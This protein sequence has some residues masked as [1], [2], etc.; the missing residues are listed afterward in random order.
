MK[1]EKMITSLNVFLGCIRYHFD[2]PND[3]HR[4]RRVSLGCFKF[5]PSRGLCSGRQVGGKSSTVEATGNFETGALRG[6]VIGVNLQTAELNFE[7][8]F[9]DVLAYDDE[10]DINQDGMD[11]PSFSLLDY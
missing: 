7:A 1:N 10:V 11:I 5:R 8:N 4:C 3:I 6:N 2:T 9:I